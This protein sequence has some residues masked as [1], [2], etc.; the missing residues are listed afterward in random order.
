MR[1][2]YKHG[3]MG[4]WTTWFSGEVD[5]PSR[6]DVGAHGRRSLGLS[7]GP[8]TFDD[9][10]RERERQ[11]E[12]KTKK[13]GRKEGRKEGKE[14]RKARKERTDKKRKEHKRKDTTKRQA[15]RQKERKKSKQKDKKHTYIKRKTYRKKEKDR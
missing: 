1:D 15:E 2:F 12:G 3:I 5:S 8:L 6:P 7:G 9:D 13:E 4:S 14:H 10:E 11:K